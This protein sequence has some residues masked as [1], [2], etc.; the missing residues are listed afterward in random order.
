[1]A[2]QASPRITLASCISSVNLDHDSVIKIATQLGNELS[3]LHSAGRIH[4]RL[5]GAHVL[6]SRTG[7]KLCVTLLRLSETPSSAAPRA[8]SPDADGQDLMLAGAAAD[9]FAFGTLLR[10]MRASLQTSGQRLP[11][12]D[13][14]IDACLDPNAER[15]ASIVS[16]MQMMSLPVSETTVSVAPVQ[17]TAK[18]P[19]TWG[20]FHLLQRLG[21]GTFGEVYRAWDPV[22]EREVAVKLL[23]PRGLNPE[24][25]LVEIVSEARAI[26]R[27]RHPGI[28]SVYGVDRHNGRVGFW[29]DFIRGRTLKRIVETE[30]PLSAHAAVAVVVALCDAL[31]AVHSAGLLHRDIK[32]SNCMRDENGRVLL[33]DFGLS[34]ELQQAVSVAGTPNYMAPE[35]LAGDSP[36]VQTDIY[37]VGVLLFYLCTATYPLALNP[38]PAPLPA[39][40]EK[41]IRKATEH[42]PLQRYD[43]APCLSEALRTV[44][45][46]ITNPPPAP[47]P[48]RRHWGVLWVLA[49]IVLIA[50]GIVLISILQR[51]ARARSAG[52]TPAA[53][54]DYLAA[55][56]DLNRYDKPGNIEKAIALFKDVLQRSPDFALAEAGLARAD[57]RKFLDTS[58]QQWADHANQAAATAA[59]MN[60]NLAPVQMTLATLHIAQGQS[61]LGME[62]LQKAHQLDP[63]SADVHAAL[64][65]AYRQQGHMDAAKK[66]F[67]TAIDLEP[68]NWRWPYLLAALHIDSGD[69]KEAEANLKI[70]LEKTP[71][72]ALVLYDLG[73]VYRKENRLPEAQRSYEQS[74][75]FNPREDTMMALGTVHMLQ[76]KTTEAI[77]MYQRAVHANPSDWEAWGNLGSSEVWG[78]SDPDDIRSSFLTAIQLGREQMKNTPDDPFLVSVL[79]YYYAYLQQPQ[80]AIPLIR[81]SL[82]LAPDDPDVLERN[83]ESYELLNNRAEALSLIGRALELGFSV[84]YAKKV[85][86]LKSLR[87]DPHAP[88]QIR[89]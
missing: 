54:Q 62:E 43:S 20:P 4:G 78:N 87:A 44:L 39:P 80:E 45:E 69:Y 47:A 37:A 23:L 60:S 17:P 10:E 70:A 7:G 71:D 25:Q 65:E 15:R 22:I 58:G 64:A 41:L 8:R 16:A 57:W 21:Q 53:Y 6:I 27:V 36:S 2:G 52:T 48:S 86:E 1:M 29:T 40:L 83:A 81:K 72:N 88:E 34:R 67:Q 76:G 59:Q 31:A 33:L 61:G 82:V 56:A 74:L 13:K 77:Q 28:V 63:M 30:G 49:G 3:A 24:Q 12:W 19:K 50:I 75:A 35:L 89:N 79:A 66:E 73:L 11:N 5:T 38:A 46:A 18:E 51:H 32:A 14:A 42:D 84:D 55:E 26:G 68:D 85:P 9:V